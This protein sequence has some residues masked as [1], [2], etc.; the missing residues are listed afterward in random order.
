MEEPNKPLTASEFL[1]KQQ[2]NPQFLAK[3][4]QYE[5]W[6][7]SNRRTYRQHAEG[8]LRDL[9]AVG[10]DVDD[11]ASLI[12]AKQKLTLAVP[13]LLRWLPKVSYKPLLQ[14][15]LGALATK[16]TPKSAVRSL[17]DLFH[18]TEDV[19]VRWSIGNA[20][21][22]IVDD[23]HFPEILEIAMDGRY[24]DART[25]F[26]LALGKM[27]LPVASEKLVEILRRDSDFA[28]PALRALGKIARP[29]TANAIAP[30]LKH[31]D[32]EIRLEAKRA[33]TKIGGQAGPGTG[34]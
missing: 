30:Y 18:R 4:K 21:E 17:L 6:K 1:A 5:E 16:A 23:E 29:E 11:V 33:L 24:G 27:T 7:A 2:S 19:E 14:D 20:L 32:A 26:I 9:S 10:A 8:L 12:A 25:M 31:S 15:M 22:V 28:W 34:L 13:V 3:A